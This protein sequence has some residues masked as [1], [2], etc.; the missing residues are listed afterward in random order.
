MVARRE[1]IA[2]KGYTITADLYVLRKESTVTIATV[3]PLFKVY[4]LSDAF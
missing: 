3:F 1:V 2:L 4:K